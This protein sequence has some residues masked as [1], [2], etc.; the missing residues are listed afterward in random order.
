M[1]QLSN[2]ICWKMRARPST[3]TDNPLLAKVEMMVLVAVEM[4]VLV[5]M[6][7]ANVSNLV[8]PLVNLP[9]CA[10]TP[11]HTPHQPLVHPY[12]NTNAMLVHPHHT[13]SITLVQPYHTTP[14]HTSC[15]WTHTT[16][17]TPTPGH[18]VTTPHTLRL[19]FSLSSTKQQF[20]KY[21]SRCKHLSLLWKLILWISSQHSF[22]HNTRTFIHLFSQGPKR[23][24][25]QILKITTQTNSKKR[26]LHG[27]CSEYNGQQKIRKKSRLFDNIY[28]VEGTLNFIVSFSKEIALPSS[29]L[30]LS[31]VGWCNVTSARCAWLVFCIL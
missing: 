17:P 28:S 26:T 31:W 3:C 21:Q 30:I 11:H 8:R 29:C 14:H 24:E 23:W 4:M 9:A 19:S 2:V 6:C 15:L 13:T 18:P 25:K 5:V 20:A 22:I 7:L 27:F 10:P 16:P 12:H 1:L